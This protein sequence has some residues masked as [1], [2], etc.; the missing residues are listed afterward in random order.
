MRRTILNFFSDKLYIELAI[1]SVLFL[2][3][4]A[5]DK[6]MDFIIYMLYFVIFLEIV[7][8][9]VNY[10]RE[11]RVSMTL[12]VDAFIILALR[13]F[14]VNVVK[15]NKEDLNT[16]EAIFSSPINYNLLILSGVILF[17][18]LIRY[19]SVITSQRNLLKEKIEDKFLN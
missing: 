18:M 6:L 10:V 19:L 7:R 13:E 12:L 1:T 11:Q 2:I 15:V 9:V 4:L 17:L 3:A 16:I 14:I 8:A 5:L